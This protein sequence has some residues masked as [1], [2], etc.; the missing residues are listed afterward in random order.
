MVANATLE[1]HDASF[2]LSPGTLFAIYDICFFL[3]AK[4]RSPEILFGHS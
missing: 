1:Q 2:L 4:E 3:V